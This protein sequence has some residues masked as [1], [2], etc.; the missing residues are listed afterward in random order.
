MTKS[1]IQNL[2]QSLANAEKIKSDGH[3]NVSLSIGDNVRQ[4]DLYIARV[5]A[6]PTGR[7]RE[8]R[9]LAIGDTQGSR[10]ILEGSVVSLIDPD[11]DAAIKS[12][13]HCSGNDVQAYQIGPA[14]EV[15]E[16]PVTIAHPEHG[17]RTLTEP[18]CYQV[19]Y[20]RALDTE[21]REMREMD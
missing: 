5:I 15:G 14:F 9:Q 18:G 1:L 21:E 12:L 7:K 2:D 3:A 19:I 17:D 16:S 11:V 6:M 8:S 4:G 20:Q 13:K 10:H